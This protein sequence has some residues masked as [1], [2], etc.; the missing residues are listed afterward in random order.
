M[1]SGGRETVYTIK[2]VNGASAE[3]LTKMITALPTITYANYK[4]QS[5]NVQSI[6]SAYTA[7]FESR[8]KKGCSSN[9]DQADGRQKR[10]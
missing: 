10:R 1:N 8:K 4:A 3:S 5:A 7:L 2:V 9:L 6:R